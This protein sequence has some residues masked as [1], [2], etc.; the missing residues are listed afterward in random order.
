MKKLLI[1]NFLGINMNINIVLQICFLRGFSKRCL[2]LEQQA[3]LFFCC[4]TD[5]HKYVFRHFVSQHFHIVTELSLE[6][7]LLI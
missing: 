2:L 5:H 7:Y 3:I 6:K 1:V 4:Y